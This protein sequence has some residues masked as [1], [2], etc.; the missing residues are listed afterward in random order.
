[1]SNLN[2]PGAGQENGQPRAVSNP[3][4]GLAS[5]SFNNPRSEAQQQYEASQAS[6]ASATNEEIEQA[7]IAPNVNL[8]ERELLRPKSRIN[9]ARADSTARKVFSN[10]VASSQDRSSGNRNVNRINLGLR[11]GYLSNQEQVAVVNSIWNDF[12]NEGRFIGLDHRQVALLYQHWYQRALAINETAKEWKA[13]NEPEPESESSATTFDLFGSLMTDWELLLEVCKHLRPIDIINLY[14]V[15]KLFHDRVNA[16]LQSTILRWTDHMA[17]SAARIFCHQLY[18]Q[19]FIDDPSGRDPSAHRDIRFFNQPAPQPLVYQHQRG[20]QVPGPVD[21]F[22]PSPPATAAPGG[23][24]QQSNNANIPAP[25]PVRK[26]PSLIWFQ[27]AVDREIK[28]RDILAVLARHGHRTPPDTHKTVKKLWL[29]MDVASC[30]GRAVLINSKAIFTDEDLYRARLFFI[31]LYLLFTDPVFGPKT[32]ALAKLFLG[33]KSFTPLWQ[34]LRRKKYTTEEEIV[35]MKTRYDVRPTLIQVL[36]GLPINGVPPNEMGMLHVEGWGRGVRHLLRPDEMVNWEAHKRKLSLHLRGERM[37]LY[38]HVDLNTG[39]PL[40]P[41]LDELYMSD[42]EL[43]LPADSNWR[44][45]KHRKAHGGCGNVPFE[46]S[47]WQ[48]K[49]ARKARWNTL[50]EE[51]KEEILAAEEDEIEED[52]NLRYMEG[53]LDVALADLEEALYDY[54]VE[55]KEGAHEESGIDGLDFDASVPMPDVTPDSED[56]EDFDDADWDAIAPYM[57]GLDPT[58]PLPD[59]MSVLRQDKAYLLLNKSVLMAKEVYDDHAKDD[60]ARKEQQR[61]WKYALEHKLPEY[62][63][64]DPV[65]RATVPVFPRSGSPASRRAFW[66]AHQGP[67][68]HPHWITPVFPEQAER[69]DIRANYI[70][71]AAVALNRARLDTGILDRVT[72]ALPDDEVAELEDEEITKHMERGAKYG[73]MLHMPGSRLHNYQ[74]QDSDD[75]EEAEQMEVDMEKMKAVIGD[76][77]DDDE[78]EDDEEEEEDED[79]DADEYEDED[80]DEEMGDYEEEHDKEDHTSTNM[81]TQPLGNAAPRPAWADQLNEYVRRMAAAEAGGN[82]HNPDM[83]YPSQMYHYNHDPSNE[84]DWARWLEQQHQN[85]LLAEAARLDPTILNGA[86]EIGPDELQRRVERAIVAKGYK[87]TRER[88]LRGYYRQW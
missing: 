82:P 1:M 31:K 53:E 26:V 51:E 55:K 6:R 86:H 9:R 72:D 14:S 40:V 62:S 39:K 56:E 81:S 21:P 38:G 70:L 5:L 43:D 61:Y 8:V 20:Y 74:S 23:G 78:E 79:E 67:E 69:P 52:K 12:G 47:M 4:P 25:V 76:D 88:F 28:V 33:Q 32:T 2:V 59:H 24:Q 18:Y 60:N 87:D 44:I 75:V 7:G 48:P 71:Q 15:S 54:A 73:W 46:R 13:L 66:T 41:T 29:L 37:M 45:M 50:T 58:A 80:E 30:T 65:C 16:N 63:G 64:P 83:P 17:P 27:M 10:R 49:H 35:E 36:E 22:P 85:D 77:F 3:L 19:Y 42:D 57:K 11:D 84:F 34:F 68:N